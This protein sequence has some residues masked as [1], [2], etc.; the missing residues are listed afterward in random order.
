M[1]KALKLQ[2]SVLYITARRMAGGTQNKCFMS[3]YVEEE[4]KAINK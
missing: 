2:N 3:Q 1:K 4:K